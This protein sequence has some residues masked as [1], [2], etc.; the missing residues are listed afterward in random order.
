MA[1]RL[2]TSDPAT[3]LERLVDDYLSSCR[4]RGLSP[5]SDRQYSQALRAVFLPWCAREGITRVDEL[6]RRTL[7]RFTSMLLG[8]RKEDGEPLSKHSVH[9]YIRPVRLMLTWAAREGE[10]VTAKPQFPRREKP[11]RDVLSREE[12]DRMEKA[13]G[14]ERDK[15]IIR[16]FGD[17]GLRLQELAR[18][19]AGDLLRSPGQ[20]YLRVHGK[21]YRIREVR[22]TP[23]LVR[24]LDRLIE[25][26]PDDRT[27]D[28]IFIAAR[29]RND[30]FDA[31]TV[32]GVYQVVKDAVERAGIRKRVYPHLLRHSW[33]TEMIRCGMHPLQLSMIAGASLDV[34]QQ[35]YAHLTRADAYESVLRIFGPGT[36]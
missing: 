8:R 20:A 4:A 17:C 24:R 12:I 13:V 29:R 6:D 33:I 16:V 27:S 9:T 18:L 11:V 7:D 22:V 5:R 23:L 28:H 10:A 25:S 1:V 19:E 35:H 32:G 21:R 2:L 36:R 26:R 30:D 15:L 31:L 3:P 34:I 14:T